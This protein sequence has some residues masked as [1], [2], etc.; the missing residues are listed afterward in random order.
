MHSPEMYPIKSFATRNDSP[1]FPIYLELRNLSNLN[2]IKFDEYILSSFMGEKDHKYLFTTGTIRI[3]IVLSL[4]IDVYFPFF[5]ISLKEIYNSPFNSTHIPDKFEQFNK[6]LK[7]EN[8]NN[9]LYRLQ[10]LKVFIK[11]FS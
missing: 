11:I 3:S 6:F 8:S 5:F 2:L 4:S 10:E 9:I 7:R 1:S